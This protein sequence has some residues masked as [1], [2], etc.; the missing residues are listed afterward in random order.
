[1]APERP[2]ITIDE[3]L[4]AD[5]SRQITRLAACEG[6]V[7]IVI[8]GELDAEL[9]FAVLDQVMARYGKPLAEDIALSG[10]RLT[11]ANGGALCMLRHRARYDVIA[12]DFLVYVRAHE[13][14]LVELSTSIAAALAHLA[15]AVG[16][17]TLVRD[18]H[19]Q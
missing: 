16:S 4:R 3:H 14:P 11:L 2:A 19:L 12:R 6:G 18:D 17:N 7:R 13:P 15:R 10:P 5:G 1:M 9:P 8:D